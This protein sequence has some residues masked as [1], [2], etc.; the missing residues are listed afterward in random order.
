MNEE[1]ENVLDYINLKYNQE[2]LP[3]YYI[4]YKICNSIVFFW[5]CGGIILNES[6]FFYTIS[7]DDGYWFESKRGELCFSSAWLPHLIKCF[8]AANNYLE[9]NGKPYYYSDTNMICGYELQS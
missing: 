2:N 6:L 5:P 3:E 8:T 1:I 7:E 4:P 9:E